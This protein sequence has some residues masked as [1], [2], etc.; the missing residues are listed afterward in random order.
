MRVLAACSLGGAGHLVP[1]L[2]FLDAAR[3]GGHET[4]VIGPAGLATMVAEAGHPFRAG[5]EPPEAAIAPIR[6][7]LPIL[8]AEQASVLGNRELFGRLA[9][10][11]MLPAMHDALQEWTPDIVLRD[12]CEYSSAVAALRLGIRTAQVA[13]GLA[14]VERPSIDVA[15]PVLEDCEKGVVE[16]L[17]SEPYLTRFAASLDASTFPDT[18][19]Y[20]EPLQASNGS[21]PDWWFG[22]GGPLV[23][24]SFGTVLGYMTIAAQVYQAV[25]DAVG[26]LDARILLTVGR[27]FDRSELVRVPPN[28]HIEPWIDQ[29]E[30]MPHAAVVLCHGGSGTTFSALDAGV[31]LVIVPLFA[32]QFVNGSRVAR[33][34]AAVV[35]EGGLD[36]QGHRLPP[37]TAAVPEIR[38]AVERVLADDSYRDSARRI[39]AEVSSAPSV[40]VVLQKLL[41]QR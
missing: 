38:F 5:G 20:R 37:T 23:Y 10:T 4:L 39:A 3:K 27:Q 12:P 21:L 36:H 11:A 7:Q 16:R 14:D 25:L 26:G 13:I 8:P 40:E 9:T 33:R 22:S 18:R 6:E 31:P 15:A 41:H 29:S 28:V 34:G 32:D 17:I 1:V 2:T 30:I 24:A 35:V 19:R